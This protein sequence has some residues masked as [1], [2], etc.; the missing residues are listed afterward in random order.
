MQRGEAGVKVLLRCEY[1]EV[2]TCLDT[3]EE[4]ALLQAWIVFGPLDSCN[5][6]PRETVGYVEH[7]PG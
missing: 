5:C 6:I 2:C 1:P 4:R 7:P 3:W